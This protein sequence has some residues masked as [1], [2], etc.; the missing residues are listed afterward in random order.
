MSFALAGEFLSTAPPDK[1]EIMLF[2]T[3]WMGLEIII[4]SDLIIL[5]L[6]SDI[7]QM[8]SHIYDIKNDTN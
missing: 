8:I 5:S 4:L 2:A 1:S 6:I 7:R 3:T